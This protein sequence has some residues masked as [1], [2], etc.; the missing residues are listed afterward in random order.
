MKI[1]TKILAFCQILNYICRVCFKK[2][3]MFDSKNVLLTIV[4]L[5]AYWINQ[6]VLVHTF[7]NTHL[8]PLLNRLGGFFIGRIPVVSVC[9]FQKHSKKVRHLSN[10]PSWIQNLA[11][12][13]RTTKT[14]VIHEIRLLM[15][16]CCFNNN[17]TC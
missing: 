17:C 16:R 6:S 9:T 12:D 15:K 3:Y 1:V 13:T 2:S 8:P 14:L 10:K 5:R 7:L 4:P 11:L